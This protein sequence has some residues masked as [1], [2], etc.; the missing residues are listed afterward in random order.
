MKQAQVLSH[1]VDCV[2][3]LVADGYSIWWVLGGI[4]EDLRGI[5]PV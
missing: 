2:T 3:L 1:N 5:R 4:F